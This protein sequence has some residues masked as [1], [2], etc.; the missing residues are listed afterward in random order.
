MTS[1]AEVRQLLR[2]AIKTQASK[3]E[4]TDYLRYMQIVMRI[5]YQ[6]IARVGTSWKD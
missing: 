4:F 5:R 2:Q 3:C 6:A 1:K